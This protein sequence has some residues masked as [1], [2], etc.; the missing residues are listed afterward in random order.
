MRAD[1]QLRPSLTPIDFLDAV[2]KILGSVTS[3]GP[4][5]LEEA[6]GV[7]LVRLPD[8]DTPSFDAWGLDG[9]KAAGTFETVDVRMPS[10][11]MSSGSVFASITLHG[12][13][14]VGLADLCRRYGRD[15]STERPSPRYPQGSVPT[16]LVFQRPWGSL[17]FGLT[18]GTD[19]RLR[20]V[21]IER[22]AASAS[23]GPKGIGSAHMRADGTLELMLRAE[24]ADG[25]VG[26]ATLII[27]PGDS[28]HAH[29]VLQLGGIKPGE[30]KSVLA[31]SPRPGQS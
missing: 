10:A 25:T 8:A 14:E 18:D 11:V 27:A 15:F 30:S 7:G 26:D 16:Y 28:R 31:L 1:T 3:L 9:A 23:T 17:S 22:R 20:R 4:G 2:D 6:L 5:L 24:E 13:A 12:A 29:M 19:G 21:V